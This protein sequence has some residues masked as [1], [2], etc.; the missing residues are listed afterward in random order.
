MTVFGRCKLTVYVGRKKFR[1]ESKLGHKDM[2]VIRAA[3]DTDPVKL[4]AGIKEALARYNR[5]Q[6]N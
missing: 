6:Q 5:E 1:C 2:H 4:E 3:K